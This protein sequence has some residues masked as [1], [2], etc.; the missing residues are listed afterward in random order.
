MHVC[1]HVMNSF[2]FK[3]NVQAG[4]ENVVD[5]LGRICSAHSI[6]FVAHACS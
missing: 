3:M 1:M 2:V 6:T 5:F 4:V